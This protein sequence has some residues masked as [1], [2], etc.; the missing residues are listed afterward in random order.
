MGESMSNNEKS[1]TLIG[2]SVSAE[3]AA[4]LYTAYL[5]LPTAR[6]TVVEQSQKEKKISLHQAAFD[7]IFGQKLDHYYEKGIEAQ[8]A[9]MEREIAGLVQRAGI[10]REEAME[11]LN[12]VL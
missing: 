10:T 7:E 11:R 4:K 12:Y 2:I 3:M 9:V 8:N 5:G 1:S 6:Q